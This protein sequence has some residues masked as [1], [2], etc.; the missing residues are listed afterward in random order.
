MHENGS[1][2]FKCNLGA[3]ATDSSVD[4]L[5]FAVEQTIVESESKKFARF[6]LCFS[7]LLQSTWLFY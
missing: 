4:S 6:S 1:F 7:L 3:A 2:F 5:L